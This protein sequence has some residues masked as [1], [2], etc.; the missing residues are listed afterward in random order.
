MGRSLRKASRKSDFAGK[1]QGCLALTLHLAGSARG[2][3][4]PLGYSKL[5]AHPQLRETKRSLAKERSRDQLLHDFRRA[6]VDATHTGVGVGAGNRIFQHV[7]I[8]AEQLQAGIE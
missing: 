6:S 7:A 8:A 2:L 5:P 3:L 1:D 4:L